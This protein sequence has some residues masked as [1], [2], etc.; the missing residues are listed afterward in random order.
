M[1]SLTRPYP[2]FCG[3]QIHLMKNIRRPKFSRTQDIEFV[4]TLKARVA[5]YFET[6]DKS[7]Q[8]NWTMLTPFLLWAAFVSNFADKRGQLLKKENI[9]QTSIKN[10][11]KINP[12]SNK[13]QSKNNLKTIKI[14][15]KS[16]PKSIRNR[17]S[18][19]SG[20]VFT[21]VLDRLGTDL[22]WIWGLF[23]GLLGLFFM[24]LKYNLRYHFLDRFL[25]FG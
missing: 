7:K 23:G 1:T 20:I 25:I 18:D 13:H 12:K 8:A 15:P 19:R 22:G 14:G 2:Y 5:D 16:I 10:R 17:Y 4:K 3:Y 9:H 24:I 6:N 21:L 11:S